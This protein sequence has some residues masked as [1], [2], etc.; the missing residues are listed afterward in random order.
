MRRDP[1][2]IVPEAAA[3]EPA[4][5]SAEPEASRWA[6]AL[7]WVSIAFAGFALLLLISS[8]FT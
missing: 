2:R 4:A 8:F 6:Q 7:F 5:A 3:G 1:G